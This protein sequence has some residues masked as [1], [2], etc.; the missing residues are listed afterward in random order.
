LGILHRTIFGELAKVF[1]LSLLGITGLIVTA[2]V[3]QEAS[4]RGLGPGQ[5]LAA[6]PL[7]VPSM[8]PF[9]VPPTTLFAACVVFGRL[10]H[11]NEIVAVK[12]A[13][14]N[15]LQVIWPGALLGIATSVITFALYYQLIPQTH[16]MLR[17][18]V[19]ND[20]EEFLYTL[21]RRDHEIRRADLKLN[22]EMWVEQ[23]QG[24]LLKNAIFKRRDAKG[25]YDVIAKARE[26]ELHVDLERQEVLVHM[27]IGQVLD[28]GGKS[29][30]YF[31][32]RVYAV[33]LPS[34]EKAKKPSP[35]SLTWR[36]LYANRE[37]AVTNIQ[38][39]HAFYER[40]NSGQLII[41]LNEREQHLRHVDLV[42]MENE[43][44]LLSID[45]ELQ[46]RPAL[47]CGCLFFVLAGCPVGIWFSR[48][49]YLSSFISCFLPVVFIYY[50]V[51]LC[52]TNLAKDGKIHPVLGLWM[53]NAV[54]GFLSLFLYRKIL[55]N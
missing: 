10:S 34:M 14:V 31:D 23:V 16:H 24:R 20:M 48:S 46:M 39:C 54:I 35:R 40:V 2:A 11:D 17:T 13:G 36:E 15:I 29:R 27:R 3:V 25:H 32:D 52:C 47:A 53:A 37:E 30:A 7:I 26:A 4:Q 41:P 19:V 38:D 12:A 18:S 45:T 44:R 43:Q 21:I 9:I 1:I 51:Q 33:P 22:Y 42:L 28:D 5:I 50:P 8:M 55:K 49:D 6:I